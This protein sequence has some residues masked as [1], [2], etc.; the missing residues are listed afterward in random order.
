MWLQVTKTHILA[1]ER[2]KQ[3]REVVA[4]RQGRKNEK[5]ACLLIETNL[6]NI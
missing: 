5:E 4:E 3:R 2:V 1:E 6:A